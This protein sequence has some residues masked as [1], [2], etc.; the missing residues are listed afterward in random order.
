[1][2]YKMLQIG[3]RYHSITG[4]LDKIQDMLLQEE[5]EEEEEELKYSR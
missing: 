2:A 5:A 4:T 1:M 3:H